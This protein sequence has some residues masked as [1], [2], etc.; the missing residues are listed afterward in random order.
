MK[1]IKKMYKTMQED[2]FPQKIEM[3]FIDE[4]ERQVLSYEK[5]TWNINDE[6]KGLRYGENPDQP[7]ALYKLISGN[8]VLGDVKQITP[9]N[10]LVTEV[11]LI[12]SGKHP[13]KIN[14]TDADAALNILKY[15][16]DD[17]CCVIVKHNN[18]CGVARAE[19]AVEAYSRALLADRIAAFGGTV[20][21]NRE[22]D[23]ETATQIADSYCEVV[24]APEYADNTVDILSQ[25]KNLRI[26]RVDGMD[27]LKSF[28]QRR[29]IEIKNLM[30]GGLITQWSYTPIARTPDA[31]TTAECE[32][33]GKKYTIDR[34]PTN[35]EYKDLLFGWLIESGVTSNSVLYVKDGVT[36]AIG[37][38]EQDRVGVAEIAKFKAYRNTADRICWQKYQKSWLENTDETIRTEVENE[39]RSI[40]GG[41]SGSTM[42]SDA[43]FPKRDGIEIGLRE[44]V[45]AVIQ[46]GGA[47]HDHE[48]IEAC[49]E[50]GATMVFTGQRSFK[51]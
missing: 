20:A 10:S 29:F 16:D 19:S 4:N 48:I 23:V 34:S 46:P 44:G 2:P 31:L 27:K 45:S 1:N 18:P 39:V 36:V 17:P 21:I 35:A 15:L 26:M 25:R 3:A 32:Y 51:H 43:F 37:T 22:L 40:N 14:I 28:A 50:Y 9:G 12:Q 41:L 11:E 33:K 7:A 42:V 49:N 13:G 8:L 38:G 30:D 5:V 24:V 47:I 6:K